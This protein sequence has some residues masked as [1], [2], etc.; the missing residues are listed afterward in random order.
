MAMVL[1][2][3]LSSA[4]WAYTIGCETWQQEITVVAYLNGDYFDSKVIC[5]LWTRSYL[6]SKMPLIRSENGY[7]R[8][9]LGN[10]HVLKA[11][12]SNMVVFFIKILY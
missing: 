7:D 10:G 9:D 5:A 11:Y 12:Y 4:S 8:F 6:R 2:L 1:V 3:A